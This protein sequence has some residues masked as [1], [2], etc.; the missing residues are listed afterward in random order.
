MEFGRSACLLVVR[1]ALILVQA[2]QNCTQQTAARTMPP[3]R[4]RKQQPESI[5]TFKRCLREVPSASEDAVRRI[6]NVMQE[7]AGRAQEKMNVR[8]KGRIM[9]E[10][11]KPL[12]NLYRLH[13]LPGIESP[14]KVYVGDIDRMLQYL[15]EHSDFWSQGLDAARAEGHEHV[16]TPVVYNDE[17]T[18][19][20]I[21]A[22]LSGKKMLAVYISFKE[23]RQGSYRE[24]CWLPLAV[25]QRNV[26]SEIAGG[27]SALCALLAKAVHS[28]ENMRG[29]LVKLP[30]GPQILRVASS[31]YLLADNDA[32]KNTF[33][34]KGS[35]GIVFCMHCSNCLRGRHVH[36]VR[37]AV[38][39]HEHDMRKLAR[40]TDAEFFASADQ[41]A[42]LRTQKDRAFREKALGLVFHPN[43]LLFDQ[44]ARAFWPPSHAC[45]DS[46]H[47][48]Y[49][50]G[51]A[52]WE[53]F[54][55]VEHLK[56]IRVPL[57]DLRRTAMAA[58][59]RLAGAGSV[60]ASTKI[61][62]MLLDRMFGEDGSA[63][64][65]D[66]HD[67]RLLL[68]LLR[69]YVWLLLEVPK[70][71]PTVAESF[72]RLHDCAR[73][74]ERLRYSWQPLGPQD[75]SW[76]RQAQSLHMQAFVRAHGEEA[77]KPKHHHRLHIPSDAEKL[78]FLPHCGL[79][80][81]KHRI[82]KSGGLV[83]RQA[84][85][86]FHSEKLQRSLL[87]RMLGSCLHDD[88][89][90]PFA[91]WDLVGDIRPS[92]KELQHRMQDE[93]LRQGPAA[94]LLQ[95]RIAAQDVLLWQDTGCRVLSCLKG[96]AGLALLVQRLE[97]IQQEPFGS[98]WKLLN[99]EALVHPSMSR[100]FTV[101]T[102]WRL[103]GQELL[104]LH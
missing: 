86:L 6:F 55:L 25:L 100:P 87:C 24:C 10:E 88:Q 53:T 54:L 49:S 21:L 31:S 92:S 5:E 62:A 47:A 27:L 65:G 13:E 44:Q 42:A 59:W 12:V 101:A 51:L 20:N 3:G 36:T 98:R 4:K 28:A 85:L 52:S 8:Q 41:L 103:Q 61:G 69:Y 7:D 1:C 9:D 34:I 99:E 83:D 70:T 43:A 15:A 93:S 18:C 72:A 33:N 37:N 79:H 77:V 90:G 74:L 29:F 35:A 40:K 57:Q 38:P 66:A 80:E 39:A 84:R 56:S 75:T 91:C 94:H 50:H 45:C 89:N 67:T 46:M 68:F 81:R 95:V 58:D 73:E 23:L 64:R 104:C 60:T 63:F 14:V 96:R 76:L 32:H 78:A 97:L 48:Y 2:Q 102:W 17:V 22:P 16:L 26:L 30:S 71:S 19:G 82:L 11:H